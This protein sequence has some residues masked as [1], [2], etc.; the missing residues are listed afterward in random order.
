[1]YIPGTVILIPRFI[2]R[3]LGL[4]ALGS[5]LVVV[6]IPT[7]A[8]AEYYPPR[9]VYDYNKFDPNSGDCQDQ[10]PPFGSRAMRTY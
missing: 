2:G 7:P 5:L 9:P 10:N 8:R 1:M 3:L 4:V 6:T